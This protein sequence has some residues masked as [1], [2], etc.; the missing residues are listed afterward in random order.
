MIS[1]YDLTTE[2]ALCKLY[3]LFGAGLRTENR[4]AADRARAFAAGQPCRP[5]GWWRRWTTKM[6]LPADELTFA[7]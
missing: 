4:A 5:A 1:G 3:Y 2:A 6:R 7:G